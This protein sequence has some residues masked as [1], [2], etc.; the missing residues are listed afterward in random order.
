MGCIGVLTLHW[1]VPHLTLPSCIMLEF[2]FM[3]DFNIFF[4]CSLSYGQHPIEENGL[5]CESSKVIALSPGKSPD[6]VLFGRDQVVIASLKRFE[7][8]LLN[9]G[10]VLFEFKSSFTSFTVLFIQRAGSAWSRVVPTSLRRAYSVCIGLLVL[11]WPS[12]CIRIWWPALGGVEC[13]SLH[14]LLKE[15]SHTR[16]ANHNR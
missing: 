8:L 2:V 16:E 10:L 13:V 15:I 1:P 11:H 14:C 6:F 12:S 7:V 3:V 9:I 4:V 5:A